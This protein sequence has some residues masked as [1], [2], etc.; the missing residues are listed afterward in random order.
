MVGPSALAAFQ[1]GTAERRFWQTHDTTEYFDA[2][3]SARV[4]QWLD[5]NR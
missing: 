1:N 2:A 5:E 4:R 3:K